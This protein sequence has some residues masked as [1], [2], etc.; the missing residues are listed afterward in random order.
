MRLLATFLD[1]FVQRGE[2]EVTDPWGRRHR[3][4]G[5]APGHRAAI[6]L[7]DPH[8][9][10]RLVAQPSLTLGEGYMEGGL[11]TPPGG[12]YDL[13]ALAT[14]N[15]R[16]A[17]RSW[18]GFLAHHRAGKLLKAVQ[19]HNPVGR[20]RRRVAH[21]YD[22]SDALFEAFL[23]ADR[24]YSCGYFE[25]PDDDLE[26][27][28]RRKKDHLA[29]KLLLRDGHRV[30]DI[31]SGWGGLALH[32]AGVV[33]VDVVGCT[34]SERQHEVSRAR[35]RRLG[36]GRRVRFDLADYRDERGP[37]D[38]IVSVG[39]FEHVGAKHY[40]EFFA[41]MRDLLAE[42]GVA[43]VHAIGR[44]G[45]PTVMDPWFR[46]YIFPGAY[47]PS[48]SEVLPAVERAGLWTTDVEIL[49]LHYADTLRRWRERFAARRERLDRLY[50]ERFCRMWEYYL[51]ASECQFR[52]GE[53]MVF[54]LQVAKRVDAVPRTRDYIV[55]AR[56]QL[57]AQN[58][59]TAS[60]NIRTPNLN[61]STGMRSSSP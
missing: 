28:Q 3:F 56:R 15:R 21:H 31:G 34:L 19:Q 42:D 58:R 52:Y 27:A 32:L 35:A 50:D 44:M 53:L 24:Q 60:A 7:R 13:L 51:T 2:L 48:L 17:R 18:A 54:Q 4:G 46:K 39:M 30:L 36:L 61:P 37:F 41:R 25:S 20:A 16:G 9:A 57:E 11:T 26:V 40:P 23:D 43:V 59:K 8:L 47:I 14:D 49:R 29:A 12:L 10:W 6:H 22:L 38:R 55:D 1:R 5:R 45:P 33:G